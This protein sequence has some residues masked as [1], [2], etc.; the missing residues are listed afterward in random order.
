MV[1]SIVR[2]VREPA[3]TARA[4]ITTIPW[5]ASLLAGRFHALLALSDERLVEA[6]T[7]HIQAEHEL[8]DS[9]RDEAVLARLQA[10]LELDAEDRLVLARAWERALDGFPAEYRARCREAERAVL[11][12]GLT[13]GDFRALA[14]A[15]PWLRRRDYL[16]AFADEP[17][18]AEAAV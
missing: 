13:F 8:S 14:R 15:L 17:A 6:L 11:M 7:R 18:P 3:S 12:N 16:D 10:W 1:T 5:P 4:T 9:A 2:D